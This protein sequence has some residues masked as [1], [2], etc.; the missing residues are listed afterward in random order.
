MD[1]FCPCPSKILFQFLV[2]N[3]DIVELE[4]SELMWLDFNKFFSSKIKFKKMDGLLN[5]YHNLLASVQRT[6]LVIY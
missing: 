1:Q 4:K 6:T 5:F 3:K 2:T